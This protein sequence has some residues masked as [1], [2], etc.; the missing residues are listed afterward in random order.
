MEPSR[1]GFVSGERGSLAGEV[2]EDVLGD[3][4]GEAGV[5]DLS[6]GGGEDQVH[7]STHQGAKRRFR[8]F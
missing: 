2:D 8:S 6:Q 3:F 1:N 5:S 4:L 7:M